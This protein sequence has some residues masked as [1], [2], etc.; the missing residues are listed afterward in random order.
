MRFYRRLLWIGVLVVL[1]PGLTP[2]YAA[3]RLQSDTRIAYNETVQGTIT[4]GD[5][6]QEWTFSGHAGDLILIDLR[7][8]S[9]SL[10]D[11]YLTLMDANGSTIMSDDDSGDSTNSRIGPY[12]LPADG[13]YTIVAGRYSGSGA[14]ALELK[15]LRTIPT[16]VPGKPLV[17]VVNDAHPSDYFLIDTG[18]D[19]ASEIWR[20]KITDD[21]PVYDA[22][23]ALYGPNGYIIGTES[24]LDTSTL[25]PIVPLAGQSYVV[26]VSWNANTTGGPYQITLSPSEM[27]LL[28]DGVAQEGS[29]NYDNYSRQHYFRGEEGDQIRVTASVSGDISLGMSISSADYMHSL[30]TSEGEATQEVTLLLTLPASTVYVIE[31]HDGSY[32]GSSGDYS[33]Q[34]DW[35]P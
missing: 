25:D 9:V 35:V 30:Y 34:I 8:D 22:F 3:P 7:A 11:T 20:I 12:P 29:I 14:Y 33:V 16:L 6:E 15:D 5:P 2:V 27:D 17:G 31:L 21:D 23:L 1:V 10:L 24:A 18:T 28:Q 19:P 13:S 26:A 4:E 32:M